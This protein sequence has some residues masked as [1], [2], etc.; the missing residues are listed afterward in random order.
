MLGRRQTRQMSRAGNGIRSADRAVGWR[1]QQQP[2]PI[3]G[4]ACEWQAATALSLPRVRTELHRCSGGS[5]SDSA[6][7]FRRFDPTRGR[8]I[9]AR[10]QA[11]TPSQPT[12]QICR[13]VTGIDRSACPYHISSGGLPGRRV[14]SGD[15]R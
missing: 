1:A 5:S 10:R 13:E 14:S 2:G 12:R 7:V 4:G 11:R 8:Q 3:T 6:R 9:M 15:P